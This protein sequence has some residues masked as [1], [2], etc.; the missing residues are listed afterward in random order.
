MTLKKL[1]MTKEQYS[2]N[3]QIIQ[4][5]MIKTYVPQ[6]ESAIRNQID[7]A[8]VAVKRNGVVSAQ[9]NIHGSIINKEIGPIIADLYKTA[10]N[11]AIRKYKPTMKGFGI[12]PQFINDVM[13]YFAKFLLNKVVNPISQTTIDFINKVLDQAI[14]EGWGVDQ[15]VKELEESD[16]PKWRARLIVRTETVRATNF[17]Q[18]SAADNSEWEME[19]QWIAIEDKRTRA[20]H[21]HAGVDGQRISL[22]EPFS[23]GLMFPG[24]PEGPPEETCNCR[25]TMG[26]FAARDLNGDLIPKK[27]KSLN[28]ISALALNRA[29]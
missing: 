12:N 10:A 9:G 15:T 21:S 2:R 26:Y 16:E 18:L 22:Y 8:V 11:L 28:L 3:Q 5:R 17:T 4:N 25:C 29:A 19:K 6:V 1:S 13:N 24:D 27:N 14:A 7:A 20:S 23:N